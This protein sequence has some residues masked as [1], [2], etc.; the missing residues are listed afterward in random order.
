V[1]RFARERNARARRHI[2]KEMLGPRRSEGWT[3][4]LRKEWTGG[5]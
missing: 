2:F 5:E 1:K 4:H 3:A